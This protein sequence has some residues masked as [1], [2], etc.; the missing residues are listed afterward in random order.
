[1]M[2]EF[3]GIATGEFS[4][5][6]TVPGH[7]RCGRLHGHRWRVEVAIR[8]GQE[9]SSGEI[10][11][12]PE[13]AAALEGLCAEVHREDV[14]AMFPGSPATAAGVALAF[15]E[16]LTMMWR[17]IVSVTVWMDDTAVIISG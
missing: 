12:L 11:G 14:N 2:I 15:R 5:S 3:T 17:T 7:L 8:A 9:P 10:H 6:H 4:A 13:L 16:R 1:M